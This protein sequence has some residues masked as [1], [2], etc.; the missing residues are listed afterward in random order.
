[1]RVIAVPN[2][3]YPPT[4]DVLALAAVVLPSIAR[5]MPESIEPS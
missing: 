5:L 1:M 4:D 2:G 3:A